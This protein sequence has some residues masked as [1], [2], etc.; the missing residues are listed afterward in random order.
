MIDYIVERGAIPPICGL[1]NISDI[2]IKTITLRSLE[3][4]LSVIQFIILRMV[5]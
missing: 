5:K 1:L 2:D 4:I 3:N